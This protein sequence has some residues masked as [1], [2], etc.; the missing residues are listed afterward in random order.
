MRIS[1]VT[2]GLTLSG[3]MLAIVG[4]ANGL[5]ERGHV[6]SLVSPRGRYDSLVDLV[7]A[8]VRLIWTRRSARPAPGRHL[9]N[10]LTA[11]DLATAIPRCDA[12][13]ATYTPTAIPV[14]LGAGLGRG[15]AYW[16]YADYPEMF[17]SRPV[18]RWILTALPRHFHAVATY[19]RASATELARLAETKAAVVG[20]GLPRWDHFRPSPSPA[21]RPPVALYVGDARPRKGLAD[22]LEAATIA[23]RSVPGLRLQIV[24]KDEPRITCP[25]P[26]E[27][28]IRPSDEA[29]AVLYRGCGVFV[30]T[31]WFEGLGIPPLEAMACG[32][33]V[34]VTDQRGARDY[35]RNGE[36]CLVVPIQA[37]EQVARAMVRIFRE[38]RL[39]ERLR[40]AG[41]H[42]AHG[43]RWE[44]ALDR[45]EA[46]LGVSKA[47]ANVS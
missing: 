6:V 44:P 27:H 41:Y 16:I 17:A 8:Q 31:S 47:H 25:V 9:A 18:E 14:L 2:P 3:G 24:T 32:A 22:F 28:V 15:R 23:Q 7:D 21:P 4:F 39:A 12:L 30:S 26:F 35:A 33:P 20:L 11:L 1:F 29:L 13:V 37:P 34:V 42:T 36:N 19:S 38:H 40:Q 46:V 43:Y 5:A 45:F 10:A